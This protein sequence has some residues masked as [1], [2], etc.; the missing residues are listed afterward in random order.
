MR[1]RSRIRRVLKWVG[2]AVCVL[3]LVAWRGSNHWY[4]AHAGQHLYVALS[5]GCVVLDYFPVPLGQAYPGTPAGWQVYHE[6]FVRPRLAPRF[7]TEHRFSQGVGWILWLPLWMPF[8][9]TVIPTVFLWW[10]DRR[11]SVGQFSRSRRVLKWAGL[12]TCSLL[13]IRN[14]M[15]G[16]FLGRPDLLVLWGVAAALTLIMWRPDRPRFPS[17]HC[18]RCGYDLTG[19]V[20]GRCPECGT[21]I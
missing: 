5:E 4:V 12:A 18:Q 13:W 10:R 19:N 8:A 16:L 15:T 1:R 14:G 9:A 2:T 21:R 7:W 3:I 17:G 11:T 6:R 20:S